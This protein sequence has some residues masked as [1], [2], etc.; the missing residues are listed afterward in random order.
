MRS[1][2][3][4]ARCAACKRAGVI[5]LKGPGTPSAVAVSLLGRLLNGRDRTGHAM[6]VSRVTVSSSL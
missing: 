4:S 1:I 5:V 6:Q 2:S 3:S